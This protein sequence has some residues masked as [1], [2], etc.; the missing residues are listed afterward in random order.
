MACSGVIEPVSWVAG[1]E[2][3]DGGM[4]ALELASRQSAS[5]HERQLVRLGLGAA[6]TAATGVVDCGRA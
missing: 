6:C 1:K 2:A 4:A 3:A 5:Q